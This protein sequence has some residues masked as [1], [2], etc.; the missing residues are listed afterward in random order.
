[1]VEGPGQGPARVEPGRLQ[2]ADVVA[3]QHRRQQGADQEQDQVLAGAGPGAGAEGDERPVALGAAVQSDL[4]LEAVGVRQGPLVAVEE[5]ADDDQGRSRG[6]GTAP[7][8][9]RWWCRAAR[10]GWWATAGPTRGCRHAGREAHAPPPG[11]RRRPAPG[12]PGRP[13]RGGGQQGQSPGGGDAGGVGGEQPLRHLPARVDAGAA[14]VRRARRPAGRSAPGRRGR[15]HRARPAGRCATRRPRSPPSRGSEEARPRAAGAGPPRRLGQGDHR[16]ATQDHPLGGD[17]GQH[18]EGGQQRV[19]DRGPAGGVD[20]PEPALS[21]SATLP[22]RGPTAGAGARL[23]LAHAPG[24]SVPGDQTPGCP[25]AKRHGARR[26][27]AA[28]P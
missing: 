14:G 15:R 18:A 21:G 4:G 11:D 7:S 25:V 2:P 5:G 17:R 12:G 6:Q 19:G 8:S 27:N 22:D 13:R 1:M 28:R 20:S 9:S 26:P 16:R 10:P 23:R 3:G 24:T